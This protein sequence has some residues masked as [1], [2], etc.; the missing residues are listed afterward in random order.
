MNQDEPTESIW[1]YY[2]PYNK[3][4]AMAATAPMKPE[5]G[6]NWA[7]AAPLD[8]EEEEVDEEEES[9]EVAVAEVDPEEVLEEPEEVEVEDS[10]IE[11]EVAPFLQ[12]NLSP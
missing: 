9:D 4:T 10:L 5:A 11:V 2:I 3:A 6:A 7:T 1:F 12:T 8:L